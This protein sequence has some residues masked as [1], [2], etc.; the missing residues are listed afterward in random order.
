MSQKINLL[1]ILRGHLSTLR[2]MDAQS[3]SRVD[4]FT[5]FLLPVAVAA[6][7]VFLEYDIPSNII[8]VLVTASSIF[9]GL[10]LNLLILVYD[11]KEKTPP[12]DPD[13]ANFRKI[14]LRRRVL[15]ELYFNIS[16]STAVSL[17]LVILCVA[18][19]ASDK[20]NFCF[21]FSTFNVDVNLLITTPL[22]VFFVSNLMLT[23]FMVVKR[24]SLL[25]TSED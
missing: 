16:Y 6:F 17:L 21:P 4:I 2:T 22:I 7:S 19:L 8:D 9:T 13:A 10:L 24:I 1:S 14:E 11:Q 23:I 18:H 25:L 3:L 12:V 15:K 20:V 5:F